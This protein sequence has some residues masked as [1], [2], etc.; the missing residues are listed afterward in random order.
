[1]VLSSIPYQQHA[2]T[3]LAYEK[4]ARLHLP[5]RAQQQ[6]IEDR[7]AQQIARDNAQAG[8]QKDLNK[9]VLPS[10]GEVEKLRIFYNIFNQHSIEI[11]EQQGTPLD[12]TV[13]H[14]LNLYHGGEAQPTVHLSALLNPI[15]TLGTIQVQ[16][17]LM[18]P[19]TDITKLKERQ[20]FIKT[21]VADDALLNALE[22]TL[23]SIRAA[24]DG[25]AWF[26]KQF[27]VSTE[28]FTDQIYW[29]E[30]GFAATST[31]N[32]SALAMQVLHSWKTVLLPLTA[33]TSPYFITL[34]GLGGAKYHHLNKRSKEEREFV[35][36]TLSRQIHGDPQFGWE[37]D[38]T[39]I[40]QA[41]FDGLTGAQN[42][43]ACAWRTD[44]G[45]YNMLH[46]MLNDPKAPMHAKI[47]LG[48]V[49]GSLAAIYIYLVI[50][51]LQEAAKHHTIANSIH[52]HM[53]PLG[54]YVHAVNA[55]QKT[56]TEH[57]AGALVAAPLADLNAFFNAAHPAQQLVKTLQTK[58]FAGSPSIFS[59]R[60]RVLAAFKT[61]FTCKD[62]FIAS[63]KAIGQLDAYVSI[64]KLYKAHANNK[65]G[66][67]CFVDYEEAKTT[68]HIKANNFWM[69]M[70]NPAAVVTNSIELGG[71]H[72]RDV[73]LTGPNAGGKSTN[74]KALIECIIFAQT[75]CIAPAQT[76]SCSPFTIIRSYMNIA[77]TTGSASLYQAEMRR[78]KSLL[79]AIKSL[80]QGQFS[81][82]IMDEVFTGTR[83]QAAVE[84]ARLVIEDILKINSCICIFATH[85]DP[86]TALEQKYPN[87]I[88]NYKVNSV[89]LPNGKIAFPYTLEP[90]IS[91]QSIG[92]ELLEQEG[93]FA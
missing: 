24:E 33:I 18:E 32:K 2:S 78:I 86:L 69:P 6:Q 40:N 14:D 41:F 30:D 81:I 71:E 4:L 23:D 46:K 9:I 65:N 50:T 93:V 77:D 25:F 58:T 42:I 80:P 63:M 47:I 51:K 19:L 52:S 45:I 43:F 68:P 11:N 87:I 44:I 82:V 12:E 72:I 91:D 64:A 79:Q 8:K 88:G 49:L 83:Y 1:L 21:L 73:I 67:Y 90:G 84:G 55:L 57:V 5:S 28:Q 74:L 61:M 70:L 53:M 38:D 39:G 3:S 60:G 20:D 10:V 29:Q 13:I 48:T 56:L 75:I 92:L 62:H 59:Q 54:Q 27:D 15:T 36:N 17:M 22:R 16:R 7:E 31:L 76:F 37:P 66:R 35:E 89:T 85:Y 26:W 34:A